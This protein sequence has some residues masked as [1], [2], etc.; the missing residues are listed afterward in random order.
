MNDHTYFRLV[1]VRSI[2]FFKLCKDRL[3]LRV[4]NSKI[5]IELCHLT[6]PSI[7]DLILHCESVGGRDG[8]EE[9]FLLARVHV[10]G[11]LPLQTE[12]E[13][14]EGGESQDYSPGHNASTHAG[15]RLV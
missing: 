15:T 6:G 14:E 11:H 7:Y 3:S 10:D 5:D 1:G 8:L 12:G 2:G 9:T 13:V 4:D